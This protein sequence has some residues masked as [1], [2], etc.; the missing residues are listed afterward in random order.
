MRI[1][2]YCSIWC[3]KSSCKAAGYPLEITWIEEVEDTEQEFDH[4]FV[5]RVMSNRVDYDVL[6]AAA[7]KLEITEMPEKLEDQDLED[8][9][10]AKMCH[11]ILVGK[12]VIKG[13]LRWNNWETEYSI[14][15]G[16]INMELDEDDL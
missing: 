14:D 9:S 11:M 8:E 1:L 3:K 2:T 16:I 12:D 7:A 5:T 10:V 4:G 15:K 13:I 6:K